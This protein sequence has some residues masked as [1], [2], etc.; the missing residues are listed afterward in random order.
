MI[1]HTYQ[2]LG[3]YDLLDVLSHYA[4]CE[5]GKSDCLSLKPSKNLKNIDNE[6]RLVSEMRLLLKVKG[7]LSFSDLT[8]IVPLLVKTRTEGS[9]LETNELLSVFMLSKTCHQIKGFLAS[10]H[11]LCPR[12]Y[13]LTS[14]MPDS[15]DLSRLISKAITSYGEIKDSASPA[16][17]R[18]RRQKTSYRSD[19]QKKLESLQKSKSISRDNQDHLVTVRDGRYVIAL[20]TDHCTGIE[21][22]IHGYSQTKVTCFLEPVEVLR[23]N[24]RLAELL[25]EEKEE[26]HRILVALTDAVRD[27]AVNLEYS[28]SIISRLDGLYA[29]AKFSENL[30]C[31]LPEIQENC[32][33]EL[34][35]A[36]NAILM[37]LALDKKRRGNKT[38]LP[39]PVDIFLDNKRNILIISGP[40]RGGKTVALKTLGLISLMVQSG[41]HIPAEEGSR[42]PVFS[43]IMA[44]IG[45]DQDI[46]SGLSTFSAHLEHLNYIIQNADQRSLIIIDEPGIG[47][48]PDEGVALAMAILDFL[49]RK[50]SL[51]AVS[52]H[53]NR[54]KNYGLLNQKTV[55]AAVEFDGKNNRPTFKIQY[56]SPGVSHALEIA[57]EIGI[58][59]GII[60]R[61]TTYLDK[62]EI[63]LNQL[64]D[65]MN[66]LIDEA[67]RKKSEAE[68]EKLKYHSA[69]E[70]LSD[71]II[72]LETEKKALF[73]EMR[74]EADA[75]INNAKNELKH[76]IN[77]LK[78]DKHSVQARISDEIVEV[79]TKLKDHFSSE[80]NEKL[81]ADAKE[82]EN[83]RSVY[84]K[85]LDQ[86]G[87]I[88][89]IDHTG[90]KVL[91]MF[92]NVKILVQ[93]QDLELIE[94]MANSD[95]DVRSSLISWDIE[96]PTVKELNVIGYRVDDALALIDQSI[97][98]AL[99]EGELTL[100]IIH[101]FGTGTLRKAIRD[102]LRNVPFIKNMSGADPRLG[103][104]A[105][106]LIEL[107]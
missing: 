37:A 96:A 98:R 57:E 40:N 41:I 3:Y 50:G 44:D 91:V 81:P 83:G 84:H 38:D 63:H 4:S 61:A 39:V 46:E 93:L 55:N 31:I 94:D 92:G 80:S 1:E 87:I 25:Q 97:N 15:E 58:H 88:Q 70:R 32:G 99:I 64:I 13:D 51:V 24:N 60:E 10:N 20:R 106:T 66:K 62:D 34:K 76:A 85:K 56:G 29:R 11:E 8:D 100:K 67:E 23:D 77:L 21:G 73:E 14:E 101:G 86:K 74:M 72:T 42:L 30:Q 16:L 103:G 19:I 22:I 71:R 48:D 82:F 36:R 107:T 104:E 9:C 33:V 69:E 59:P 12:V 49:S 75:V 45:D 2:V 90:E 105:I 35:R 78:K 43:K 18:L 68:N 89:S 47:T 17:K 65:K 102:H 79:S 27:S 52:T 5:L 28:Q 95:P 53:F 26:E 7:F 6:L 54:L